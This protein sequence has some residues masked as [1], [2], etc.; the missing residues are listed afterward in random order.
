MLRILCLHGYHGSAEVL[1]NQLSPLRR[2][3]DQLG[4]FVCIDAPSIAAGDFGWWHAVENETTHYEGWERTRDWLLAL[5]EGRESFDG[6]FGFSQGAALAGL[7]V[8]LRLPVRFAVFAGGFLARDQSLQTNY[9]KEAAAFALP[10]LHMIG[11]TDVIVPPEESRRLS[12]KFVGPVVLEHEGGHVIPSTEVIAYRFDAFLRERAE[13]IRG[14]TKP[15]DGSCEPPM[16]PPWSGP[17]K[18]AASAAI[19]RMPAPKATASH[20][21]RRSNVPTRSTST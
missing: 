10:S 7:L 5:F 1:R 20:V 6:V 11:R 12:A 13:E 9:D 19:E 16:S 4:E 15:H 17:N 21:S 18:R 2:K 3:V 14:A 8:G